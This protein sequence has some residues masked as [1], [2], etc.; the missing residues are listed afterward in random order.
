[1]GYRIK[2]TSA[3]GHQ[4]FLNNGQSEILEIEDKTVADSLIEDLQ[5]QH[6]E[7]KYD[8]VPTGTQN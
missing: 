6:P 3:A 5:K 4:V 2:K 8:L 1:M 7:E